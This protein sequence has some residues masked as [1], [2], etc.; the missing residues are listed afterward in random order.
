[1]TTSMPKTTRLYVLEPLGVG[2]I[3]TESLTSYVRRLAAAHVVSPSALLRLEVLEPHRLSAGQRHQSMAPV[4]GTESINGARRSRLLVDA[5]EELTGVSRVRET[6]LLDRDRAVCFDGAFR[7][8]R[9]WCPECLTDGTPYDRLLWSFSAIKTCVRHDCRLEDRCP[10]ARCGKPHRPWHRSASPGGC[11]F[12]GE[13]LDRPAEGGRQTEPAAMELVLRDFLTLLMTGSAVTPDSIARGVIALLGGRTWTEVTQLTRVSRATLCGIRRQSLRPNV[14]VL[15]R[16]MV[17]SGE[18]VADFLAHPARRIVTR[19]LPAVSSST[20]RRGRLLVEP[21]TVV[22]RALRD[23][24]ARPEG[25]I[26]SAKRFA[27]EHATTADALRKRWPDAVTAL[28]RAFQEQ[29]RRRRATREAQEIALV[30][31]A[32]FTARRTGEPSRRTVEQ[33]L[34]RPALFRQPHVRRAYL[35][36]LVDDLRV[37]RDAA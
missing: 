12:C 1:M 9:A 7:D 6:S 35:D 4:L 34:R 14:D 15:L 36:A 3:E 30:R 24:L 13:P 37:V 32:V 28:G 19:R 17:A 20:L 29:E 10:R 2:T 23:A 18:S 25:Q 26:P 16:L 8:F 11:P 33:L 22:E 31:E 5:L 21:S 27:R